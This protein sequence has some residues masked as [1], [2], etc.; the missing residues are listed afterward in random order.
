[1]HY[2]CYLWLDYSQI[3]SVVVLWCGLEL[4]SIPEHYTVICRIASLYKNAV[5]STFAESV[6]LYCSANVVRLS[7]RVGF[8]H[9]Q[10]D[11]KDIMGFSIICYSLYSLP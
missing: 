4:C 5:V 2:Y 7:L 6:A 10:D 3:P 9:L 8:Q 1:M 11:C